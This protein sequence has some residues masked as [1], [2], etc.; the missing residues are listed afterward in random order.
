MSLASIRGRL[1]VWPDR[2]R[3]CSSAH[4]T[5]AIDRATVRAL[6]R[7]AEG[8]RTSHV[9]TARILYIAGSGRS[10]ST[11][12]GQ[13]LGQIDGFFFVGEAAN[14]WQRGIIERRPCGCGRPV[15]D[16]PRWSAII[17]SGFGSV[18]AVDAQ[19]LAKL[20][21]AWDHPRS[22]PRLV[23]AGASRT[24]P[25]FTAMRSLYGSIE[26]VTRSSVIV[27]SSKS[28]VYADVLERVAEPNVYVV[29]LIRDPRAAAYSW[30]RR[31]PLP[32]FGDG[33]LMARQ[34]PATTARRWTKAQLTTELLWGRRAHRYL[35]VTYEALMRDP[36]AVLRAICALV[37]DQGA[38][39]PLVG[40]T[41]AFFER[42]HAVSGNP[43][44]F[45]HGPIDLRL[46]D[47]W[48]TSLQRKD[49][50]VV[51]AVTWPLLMRYGFTHRQHG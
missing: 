47:E 27:D 40:R 14:L 20:A 36:A 6:H 43:G 11:L 19:R 21:R 50:W 3:E 8:V 31:K 37:G 1:H 16:C 4:G 23:F 30:M 29:H 2:A 42:T 24:D 9:S 26:Y 34:T 32:D 5:T 12:L 38:D 33:R 44:R 46:D 13:L 17:R 25:Y 45:T 39:L 7:P 28:P 41:R 18:D 49:R 10:G 48:R 35:R 22:I 15:P 51:N